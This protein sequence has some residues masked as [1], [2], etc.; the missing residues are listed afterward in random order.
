MY[1]SPQSSG[2][3]SS[4]ELWLGGAGS[5]EAEHRQQRCNERSLDGRVF[6]STGS[7]AGRMLN[8][9]CAWTGIYSSGD[10][11]YRPATGIILPT[12][13]VGF[14]I[15]LTWQKFELLTDWN[16]DHKYLPNVLFHQQALKLADFLKVISCSMILAAIDAKWHQM[17]MFIR[18]GKS[19]F[20]FLTQAVRKRDNTGAM[21]LQ[22]R[23]CCSVAPSGSLLYNCS[24]QSC[25]VLQRETPQQQAG[26]AIMSHQCS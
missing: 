21:C 16:R 8:H 20:F 13:Y 25:E 15:H 10:S 6:P 19:F 7:S 11:F 24:W 2:F 18:C 14:E 22:L 3:G 5:E 4:Y 1:L 23:S 17:S 12:V 26:R 9:K